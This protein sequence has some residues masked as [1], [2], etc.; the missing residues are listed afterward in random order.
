MR[1]L[2]CRRSTSHEPEFLKGFLSRFLKGAY[3]GSISEEGGGVR[4]L[5]GDR[6]LTN[7][8]L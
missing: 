5:Q 8:G 1:G 4:V 7:R 2:E 3:R 6:G